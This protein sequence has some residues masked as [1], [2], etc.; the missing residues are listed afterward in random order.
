MDKAAT[1]HTLGHVAVEQ[2]N[3]E[4][5]AEYFRRSRELYAAFQLEEY[6]AEEDEML[7]YVAAVA[8]PNR[9]QR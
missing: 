2:Q 5:A 7:A 4:Q 8:S 9:S 1:L 6:V 3:H